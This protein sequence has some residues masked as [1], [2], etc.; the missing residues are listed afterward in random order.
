MRTRSMPITTDLIPEGKSW[1]DLERQDWHLW[2]LAIL[3]LFV[4]GTSLLSFMFPS[5]Y[6]FGQELALQAPQRAFMGFCLL[7]GL[8]LIYMLQRQ[9]TIRRLKRRLFGAYAEKAEAER[10]AAVQA[11]QTLPDTSQ[12]RDALAM[13]YRRAITARA[14]LA[15]LLLGLQGNSREELGHTTN[16]LRHMLRHGEALFRLSD[17]A[18][19]AILPNMRATDAALFAKLVEVNVAEQMPGLK[20]STTVT[21][22][23]ENAA[24]LT[25]LERQMSNLVQ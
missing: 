12:F 4:L 10:L 23:P 15:L 3:L 2:T 6:W 22:Y 16:L 9:A 19:G 24:S 8:V 21:A 13:E 20:L 11:F 25:E 5:V 7:L 17:N 1:E 18:L 14:H